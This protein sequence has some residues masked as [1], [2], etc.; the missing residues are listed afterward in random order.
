MANSVND[1][2]TGLGRGARIALL[3][4]VTLLLALLMWV[5]FAAFRQDYGVLFAE[6]SEADAGAVITKLK[7]EKV[8]YRL[9]EDGTAIGDALSL[10]VEKLNALDARQKEKVK[11][12]LVMI[13]MF[14]RYGLRP[15]SRALRRWE[16]RIPVCPNRQPNVE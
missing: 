5:T 9:S 3:G 8:P 4:G 12:S 16:I 14:L 10:A 7:H 6:L 1:F 2:W 13:L 11:S 15:T